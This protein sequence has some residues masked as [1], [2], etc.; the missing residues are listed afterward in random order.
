MSIN[1]KVS[2]LTLLGLILPLGNI[3]GMFL[4]RIPKDSQSYRFR[5]KLL[6]I[7]SVLTIVT[8]IVATI[9]NLKGIASGF[10]PNYT[11]AASYIII[12]QDIAIIAIAAIAAMKAPKS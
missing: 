8:F 4:V 3:W 10:N 7:E 11:S 1:K 5:R 2:L 12:A 6:I 9:I